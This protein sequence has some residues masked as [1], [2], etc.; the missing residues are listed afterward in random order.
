MKVE[1]KTAHTM[2]VYKGLQANICQAT[3][4]A[5]CTTVT[6]ETTMP[7]TLFFPN[8]KPVSTEMQVLVPNL[9]Q[10]LQYTSLRL[11][12]WYLLLWER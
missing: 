6:N 4:P 9:Q 10:L 1:D 2:L 7:L 5:M 3:Y 8:R 11:V 12:L